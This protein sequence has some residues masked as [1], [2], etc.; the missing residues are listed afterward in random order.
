MVTG[1]LFSD[2]SRNT[3]SWLVLLLLR[4]EWDAIGTYSWGPP[5]WLGCTMCYATG[6]PGAVGTPT[7]KVARTSYRFRCGSVSRSLGRT[8]TRFRYALNYFFSLH[9]FYVK[10]VLL[11]I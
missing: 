11:T 9:I 2:G 6:A 3:I 1:L 7:S 4:L 5:H 8:V 10:C